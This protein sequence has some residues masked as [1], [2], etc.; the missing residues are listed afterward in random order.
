MLLDFHLTG[1]LSRYCI[2]VMLLHLL[3]QKSAGFLSRKPAGDHKSTILLVK[4]GQ[5][6]P[7]SHRVIISGSLVTATVSLCIS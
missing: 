1:E 6:L 7:I 5:I 3:S 2:V 4:M